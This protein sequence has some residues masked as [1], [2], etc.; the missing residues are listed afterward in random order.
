MPEVLV[1]G[2]GL[3]GLSAALL[4]RQHDVTVTVLERRMT[5]SPQPKARRLNPRTMEIFRSAGGYDAVVDAAKGL[6]HFQAMRAGRTILESEQLP[7]IPQRDLNA[8]VECTPCAATLC[9]QDLL[10]PVLRRLAEERGADIRFGVEVSEVRQDSDGVTASTTDGTEFRAQYLIA[11]DGARSPIRERLG[12]TRS[13]RGA[14][15]R[16]T[17]VYF[18]SDL[19]QLVDGREFNICQVENDILPGAFASVDGDRRWMFYGGDLELTEPEWASRIAYSIGDPEIPVQIDSVLSWEPTMRI[20]DTYSVGRVFL[21]G[22]A[23]HV[24]TPWA[25]LGANTGIQDAHNLAWKLAAAVHGV[26]GSHLLDSYAVERHPIGY[27]AAEQSSLRTGGLRDA[28]A[29]QGLDPEIIHPLALTMGYQYA[30]GALVAGG[31]P[32]ATDR[33]ELIG[34][35]GTRVPHLWLDEGLSTL[36]LVNGGFA[37]LTTVTGWVGELPAPEGVELRRD[38]LTGTTG[39]RWAETTGATA[40]LVRPDGIVAWRGDAG[41]SA[42]LADQLRSALFVALG[43]SMAPAI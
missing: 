26:A 41:D 4:L 10:E 12:I 38:E 19:A 6:A 29:W 31:P 20:A 22:D 5:T 8:L 16:A 33:L 13:G 2:G 23:A 7:G 11:A 30:A 39:T 15:H 34:R 25:A 32:A 37:V 43:Y 28:T 27:L 1:V 18:R 9:A 36:D 3:V 35:P 14:L 40:V 24:M 17:T 21:A 42:V